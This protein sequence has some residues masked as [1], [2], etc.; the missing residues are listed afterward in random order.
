MLKGPNFPALKAVLSN[1]RGVSLIAS[2]GVSTYDDIK[3]LK[4]LSSE[5]IRGCIV[6]KAI[7][8][9]VIDLKTAVGMAE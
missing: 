8:E 9:K 7:Y 2:G 5:G 3:K 4:E 1:S 6:G